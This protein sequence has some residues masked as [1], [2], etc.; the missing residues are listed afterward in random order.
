MFQFEIYM[1]RAVH[2]LGCTRFFC[3]QMI[4]RISILNDSKLSMARWTSC[5]GKYSG[6]PIHGH[7]LNADTPLNSRQ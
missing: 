7:L 3:S 2:A 1:L 6:T 4:F 5:L